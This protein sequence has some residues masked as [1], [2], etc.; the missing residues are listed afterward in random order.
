LP[1][2]GALGAN[3]AICAA[4]LHHNDMLG[5]IDL[6]RKLIAGLILFVM[7]MA[8]MNTTMIVQNLNPLQWMW[9]FLDMVAMAVAAYTDHVQSTVLGS[10]SAMLVTCFSRN[11]TDT[12]IFGVVIFWLLQGVAL[13]ASLFTALVL[14]PAWQIEISPIL[15]SLTLFYVL[16]EGFIVMV[17]RELT[18]H[19]NADWT[20][21]DELIV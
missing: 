18:Y 6:F 4:C 3:W 12:L 19:L 17:W 15:A 1:P 10:L 16:R 11:K 9:I 13:L 14:L 7:L 8:L 21:R 2:S 20:G 5:W